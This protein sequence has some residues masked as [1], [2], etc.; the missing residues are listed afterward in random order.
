MSIEGLKAQVHAAQKMASIENE[1]FSK[2]MQLCHLTDC[3]WQRG[4]RE[5]RSEVGSVREENAELRNLL[6][7]AKSKS[8][9]KLKEA[10]H[11]KI[12]EKIGSITEVQALKKENKDLSDDH[13]KLQEL[14]KE[15]E[16]A[17]ALLNKEKEEWYT[18][19]DANAELR[20]IHKEIKNS[21]FIKEKQDKDISNHKILLQK[22]YAQQQ[23]V[24]GDIEQLIG[25]KE[26]LVKEMKNITQEHA[27]LQK[28]LSEVK[29]QLQPFMKEDPERFTTEH[30]KALRALDKESNKKRKGLR[31]WLRRRIGLE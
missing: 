29:T 8:E 30:G 19:S 1:S 24:S 25:K 31:A 22:Y 13:K 15:K 7:A 17:N 21:R 6:S 27:S 28:M 11:K 12:L 3:K 23:E 9:S 18:M 10:D 4:L 20:K 2:E 16:I 14:L 5:L 26:E